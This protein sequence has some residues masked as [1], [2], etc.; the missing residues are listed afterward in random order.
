MKLVLNKPLDSDG[1]AAK[2]KAEG[3]ELNAL[4]WQ[5]HPGTFMLEDS[6]RRSA[7]PPVTG[8]GGQSSQ[9]PRPKLSPRGSVAACS[10]PAEAKSSQGVFARKGTVA[11]EPIPAEAMMDQKEE[12]KLDRAVNQG[13]LLVSPAAAAGSWR[14]DNTNGSPPV[15]GIPSPMESTG[16]HTTET[17]Q[18]LALRRR[19]DSTLP[20][21]E[22]VNSPMTKM[23]PQ[24][25][26]SPP[27][28]D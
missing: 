16:S 22:P 10:T 20:Q 7:S 2:C 11:K 27:S 26:G 1:C 28:R 5:V 9:S 12:Q 24:C 13:G 19:A 8:R 6:P 25:K 15:T 4:T 23:S 21:T 18:V 14:L 17:C 3:R